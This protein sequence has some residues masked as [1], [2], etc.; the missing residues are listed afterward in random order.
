VN[1]TWSCSCKETT[2]KGIVVHKHDIDE[3]RGTHPVAETRT[4]GE[5]KL[6]PSCSTSPFIRASFIPCFVTIVVILC[7]LPALLLLFSHSCVPNGLY[8]TKCYRKQSCNFRHP[9]SLSQ[10]TKYNFISCV[11][12]KEGCTW[13]N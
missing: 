9:T 1:S 5:K 4:W 7:Y 10:H 2:M 11:R 3:S 12:L 8:A 6:P 13:Q